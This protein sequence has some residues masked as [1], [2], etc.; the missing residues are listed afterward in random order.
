M[1]ETWVLCEKR[2]LTQVS[3]NFLT[4]RG[5]D[6]NPDSGERQLAVSGNASDRTA[7]GAGPSN[8]LGYVFFYVATFSI[9]LLLIISLRSCSWDILHINSFLYVAIFSISLLHFCISRELQLF[10]A[11]VGPSDEIFQTTYLTYISFDSIQMIFIRRQFQ[12]E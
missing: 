12:Q 3:G 1:E 11:I 4:C 10:W 5:Q 2:R 7:I 6:S 8:P 9:S